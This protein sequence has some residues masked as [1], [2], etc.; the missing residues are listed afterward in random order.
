MKKIVTV[1]LLLICCAS[2]FA[3]TQEEFADRIAAEASRTVWRRNREE[4]L[5]A[6]NNVLKVC[7][8]AAHAMSDNRNCVGRYADD[9]EFVLKETYEVSIRMN[10]KAPLKLK[11][12]LAAAQAAW[13][14]YRDAECTAVRVYGGFGNGAGMA[15]QSCRADFA[16]ERARYLSPLSNKYW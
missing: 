13:V 16:A 4:A 2:A 6:A 5:A 11:R 7:I 1:L 9:I 14:K 15:E 12:A 8:G 10:A 3:E